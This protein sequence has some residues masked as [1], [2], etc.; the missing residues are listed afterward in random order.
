MGRRKKEKKVETKEK[1]QLGNKNKEC[2]VLD[3]Y[4]QFISQL[5]VELQSSDICL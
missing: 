3:S 5:I 1:R 2:D 4:Y